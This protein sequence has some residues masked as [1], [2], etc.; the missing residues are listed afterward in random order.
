MGKAGVI[1]MVVQG[2]VQEGLGL[3]RAALVAERLLMEALK[4]ASFPPDLASC[5]FQLPR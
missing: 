1:V 5:C 3:Q 2:L 4:M